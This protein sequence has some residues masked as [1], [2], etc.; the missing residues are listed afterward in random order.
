M[1][2]DYSS[3]VIGVTGPAGAGKS[4]VARLIADMLGYLYIDVDSLGHRALKEKQDDIKKVFGQAVF[5]DGKI[6]RKKLGRLVFSSA[7]RLA[8]LEAILHPRMRELA[9]S[10]VEANEGRVVLDAAVLGRMG[11]AE[12]CA[13]ILVVKAIMPIRIIRLI[14]RD[15]FSP[16][17]ISGIL[18]AQRNL[19]SQYFLHGVDTK[20][21]SN[22]FFK[23]CLKKRLIDVIASWGLIG[24]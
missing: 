10:S 22:N 15:G 6:D 7:E 17:R 16:A 9:L 24:A 20:Y 8:A 21:I 11:L 23:A 5:S 4:T 19:S 14:R 2:K 1:R 3:P 12:I 13:H 18:K